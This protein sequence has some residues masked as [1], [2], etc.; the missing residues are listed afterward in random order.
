MFKVSC[1]VNV[2]LYLTP[3]QP[4]PLDVRLS[5]FQTSQCQTSSPHTN[6][7][8]CFCLARD[9]LLQE[10]LGTPMLNNCPIIKDI[11]KYL[12]PHDC[13][14]SQ[15]TWI[16]VD[17]IVSWTCCSLL[18][19]VHDTICSYCCVYCSTTLQTRPSSISGARIEVDMTHHSFGVEMFVVWGVCSFLGCVCGC[20]YL[21]LVVHKCC[22]NSAS[23][24]A[25][26]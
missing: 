8:P 22:F 23:L 21:C 19:Q 6:T 20:F 26:E 5:D 2:F 7:F 15:T 11:L 1:I 3:V 14:H 10:V 25:Y 9:S 4:N 24:H 16:L 18:Q 12:L 17:Q 13:L